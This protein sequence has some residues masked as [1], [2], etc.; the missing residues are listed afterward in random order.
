MPVSTQQIYFEDVRPG[1]EV[2]PLRKACTTQQLVMWAGASGDFSPIHYD[3]DFARGTGLSGVI[4]Q[5]GLK[6]ACIGQLLHDWIAPAGV[7]RR[8]GCQYRGM[9]YPNQDLVCHAVVTRA[10]EEDGEGLVDLD[11]WIENVDGKRTTLGTARVVL[12]RRPAPGE[13]PRD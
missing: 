4:V 5:G 8:W 2:P 6:H 1:D 12:P 9:D 3:A 11:V 13:A 7:L 10:V